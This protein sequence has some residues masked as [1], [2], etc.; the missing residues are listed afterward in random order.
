MFG[1]FVESGASDRELVEEGEGAF[2]ALVDA[3]VELQ[4]EGL[5]R[6]DDPILQA[7]FVWSVTHGIAMLVI[8]GRL[9]DSDPAGTALNRYAAERLRAAISG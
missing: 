6:T 4:R 1:R 2:R 9:G 8:D 3:L 5:A 7:R